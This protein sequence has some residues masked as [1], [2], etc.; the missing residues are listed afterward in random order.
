MDNLNRPIIKSKIESVMKK[1]CLQTKVQEWI[2]SQVNSTKHTNIQRTYISSS[3]T[4]PKPEKEETLPKTNE[5]TI[6]LIPKA[7]K[8]TT[9]KENHRPLS[10]MKIDAKILNKILTN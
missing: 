6:T 3:Q 10:L 4:L 5:A 1:N 8:D 9:K 7:D 2:A